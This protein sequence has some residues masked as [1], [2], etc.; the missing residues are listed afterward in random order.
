MRGLRPPSA[1][2]RNPPAK[3][4]TVGMF[5]TTKR[6]AHAFDVVCTLAGYACMPISKIQEH[7]VVV[8]MRHQSKKGGRQTCSNKSPRGLSQQDG[9]ATNLKTEQ[10]ARKETTRLAHANTHSFTTAASR[11]CTT[12]F[13][14]QGRALEQTQTRFSVLSQ[15]SPGNKKV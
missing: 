5:V 3:K 6:V 8:M 1:T 10:S 15:V 4:R 12:C 14:R 7:M 9:D 13:V 2:A 11:Q